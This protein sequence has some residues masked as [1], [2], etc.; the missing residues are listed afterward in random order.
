[1]RIDSDRSIFKDKPTKVQIPDSNLAIMDYGVVSAKDKFMSSEGREKINKRVDLTVE[2]SKCIR[3][4]KSEKYSGAV[5]TG[6]VSHP[7]GYR[8]DE[9]VLDMK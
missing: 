5:K 1:M 4:L 2:L 3:C 9:V 7:S 6:L 8:N